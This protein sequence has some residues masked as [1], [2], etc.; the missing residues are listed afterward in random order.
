MK[1]VWFLLVATA[2]VVGG[3]VILGDNVWVITTP[4]TVLA[5]LGVGMILQG[6]DPEDGAIVEYV[7]RD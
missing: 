1:G 4:V 2:V 7:K 3:Y 5:F 6:G